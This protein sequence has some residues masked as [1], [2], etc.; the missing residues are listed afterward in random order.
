L[1]M[2]EVPLYVNYCSAEGVALRISPSICRQLKVSFQST[3]PKWMYLRG[4]S[5][6]VDAS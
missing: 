6:S 4:L 5:E 3:N 1:L 2:S